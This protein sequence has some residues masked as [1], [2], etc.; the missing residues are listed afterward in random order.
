LQKVKQLP[1]LVRISVGLQNTAGQA[2]HVADVIHQIVN[3]L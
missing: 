3:H 1:P 2:T